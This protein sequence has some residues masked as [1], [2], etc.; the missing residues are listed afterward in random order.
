MSSIVDSWVSN[1]LFIIKTEKLSLLLRMSFFF[2]F[3]LRTAGFHKFE[4]LKL[5]NVAVK[6]IL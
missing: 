2:F 6:W 5:C 3:S 1:E 4:Q